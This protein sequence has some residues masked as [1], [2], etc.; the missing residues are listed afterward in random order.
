[1]P[2]VKVR[3]PDGCG[4]AE[5]ELMRKAEKGAEAPKGGG[6]KKDDEGYAG[7]AAR[8]GRFAPRLEHGYDSNHKEQNGGNA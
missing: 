6:A 7:E 4:K 1:M 5:I 3:Y 8:G 2:R